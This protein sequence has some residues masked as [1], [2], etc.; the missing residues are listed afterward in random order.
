MIYN[1][2]RRFWRKGINLFQLRSQSAT[3]DAFLASYPKSGRTWLRFIL[4][5]YFDRAEKLGANVNLHTM[6]SVLPNY[7]L[8]NE[9]GMGAFRFANERPNLPL[10][11][12]SHF[13]YRGFFFHSKRIIFMI[14]DPRDVMVSAYFHA[15]RHKHRFSGD[16][17]EFIADPDQGVSDLVR[18]LNGW[19]R[20]LRK[21]PHL[22]VSYEKLQADTESRTADVLRFLNRTID[23]DALRDAIAASRFEAMRDREK[24][25]GI[26]DHEYNRDDVESLRMRRGKAG[27]FTD[28]LT[29]AHVSFIETTLSR[30]LSAEAKAAIR[31]TG[32][33]L[34]KQE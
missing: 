29:P 18:Y 32:L 20:G 30:Q 10:I 31:E 34:L 1:L 25:E 22:I 3:A 11:L 6:F 21:H 17:T 24:I 12:V 33:D 7:A 2:P 15:T 14:R 5:N 27:G 19:A 4:S 9:R 26:P 23:R 13:P 8:D 16:M 28:Y